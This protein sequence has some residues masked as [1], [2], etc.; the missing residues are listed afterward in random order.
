MQL[1]E[2]LMTSLAE[3]VSQLVVGVCTT[4]CLCISVYLSV[5][6]CIP[7]CQFCAAFS[8]AQKVARTTPAAEGNSFVE[9]QMAKAR[10]VVNGLQNDVTQAKKVRPSL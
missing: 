6:M 10:A 4:V 9:G 5:P 2:K 7:I 8:L 1:Y 3:G